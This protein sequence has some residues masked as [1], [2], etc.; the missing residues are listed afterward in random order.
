MSDATERIDAC[1]LSAKRPLQVGDVVFLRGQAIV[2]GQ[3]RKLTVRAVRGRDA[4]VVW[5]TAAGEL[6]ESDLPLEALQKVT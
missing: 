6:H 5:F 3:A 1:E 4:T 2:G